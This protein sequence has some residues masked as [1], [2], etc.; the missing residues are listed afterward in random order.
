MSIALELPR[1]VVWRTRSMTGRPHFNQITP[2]A[3]A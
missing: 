1:A 3:A 2:Q